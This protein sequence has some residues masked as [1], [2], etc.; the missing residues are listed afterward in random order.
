MSTLQQLQAEVA[1]RMRHGE[2][3]AS[4][5]EEVIDPSDLSE[6]EKAA[7]WLYGWSFVNWRRQRR[8]ALRHI[9]LLAAPEPSR[10]VAPSRLRLVNLAPTR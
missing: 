9:E 7:L 5:E 3:F 1:K 2:R 10:P 4:V 8:E 6:A